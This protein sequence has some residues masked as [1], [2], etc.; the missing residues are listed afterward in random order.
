ML[1]QDR[2]SRTPSQ[3]VMYT[4]A[5]CNDCQRAK[6]FLDANAIPYVQIGIE[7]NE[8]ATRFVTDINHGYH[9][10]PTIVFPDGGILVEPSWEELRR[11]LRLGQP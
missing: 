10:V 4:T 3:I 6:A 11:K 5:V 2:Y 7:G 1:T 8:E 9:S